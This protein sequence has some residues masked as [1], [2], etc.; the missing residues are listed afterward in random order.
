MSAKKLLLQ[1]LGLIIVTCQLVNVASAEL[2]KNEMEDLRVSLKKA[3][4]VFGNAYVKHDLKKMYE[5]LNTEY[6]SRVPLWEYKD[7]VTFDGVVDGFVKLDIIDVVILPSKRNGNLIYGKVSQ[8]L[9]SVENLK[10]KTTG[11]TKTTEEEYVFWDDWVL[12][13]GV[14]YKIEKV[15]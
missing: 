9:S 7:S 1:I 13:D 2:S 15:E 12:R 4:Q 8:K 14:W 6:R 11:E 3:A 10:A 5:M